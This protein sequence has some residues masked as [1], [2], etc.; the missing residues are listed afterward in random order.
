MDI[1]ITNKNGIKQYIVDGKVYKTF[2][3]LPYDIK[4]ILED[5]N[6]NGRI[7]LFEDLEP[8]KTTRVTQVQ[9]H[10]KYSINGKEY[11]SLEEVP[12][13]YRK[14]IEKEERKLNEDEKSSKFDLKPQVSDTNNK[15]EYCPNCGA[16]IDNKSHFGI[17]R[18]DSCRSIFRIRKRK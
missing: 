10:R 12:Y 7:D 6:Q 4:K 1:K 15:I 9:T 17:T 14:I 5:K 8:E 13:V 2:E 11:D 16:Q 3:E 18:C